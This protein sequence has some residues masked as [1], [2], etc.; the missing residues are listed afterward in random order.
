M[1]TP[2]LILL[3]FAIALVAFLYSSV[4]HAGASGYIA[5]MT[6]FGLATDNHSADSACPE[7]P[8]RDHRI[9]SI[10]AGRPFFL[11][12]ILAFCAAVGSSSLSRRLSPAL[13]QRVTNLDWHRAAFFGRSID[14]SAKRS[15]R[16]ESSCKTDCYRRRGRVGFALRPNRHRWWNFPDTIAAFLPMGT[17][18]TS[19]CGFC[20]LYSGELDW[21]TD[22]LLFRKAFDSNPGNLSCGSRDCR[23]N[24]WFLPG[25]PPFA[26]ARHCALP[27]HGANHR[28]YKINFHQIS[29]SHGAMR[30]DRPAAGRW[31]HQFD[32]RRHLWRP[33]VNLEILRHYFVASRSEQT[34][35]GRD[36]EL[37]MARA[38]RPE[39]LFRQFEEP[40]RRSQ[41]PAV[42]R[43]GWM[44]EIFLKMHE[45]ARGLNQ[46]FEEIIVVTV[47]V[48]PKM[49]EHIVSFV[50]ALVVPASKVSAIKRMLRHFAGKFGIV[51]FQVSNELRNSFAFAHEGLNFSMPQM[52]GKPTFPEGPDNIRRRSQ[53]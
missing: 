33:R 20:A 37:V 48:E 46:S 51:A 13:G 39:I 34:E 53:E 9:V 47:R 28:R 16:N 25:K 40:R 7:H 1:D 11:E 49:F 27:R 12:I 52:M 32:F 8:G 22:W 30:R 38:E 19:S 18:Q 14:F 15:T 5:T 29:C 6:L 10:L 4:G 50:V 45:R 43:M 36:V 44:F 23:W 42:F 21:W 26:C 17:D 24:G 41:A 31:L 2:Q 3:C 35:K